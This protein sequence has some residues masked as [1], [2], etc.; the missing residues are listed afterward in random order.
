M[1]I[2]LNEKVI[3]R[4]L[5]VVQMYLC[6]RWS[7]LVSGGSVSQDCHWCLHKNINKCTTPL[8]CTFSPW[9]QTLSPILLLLHWPRR[10]LR[11]PIR[12]MSF[13]IESPTQF[14]VVCPSLWQTVPWNQK[15]CEDEGK[16][17]RRGWRQECK[18][19]AW[20]QWDRWKNEGK[21]EERDREMVVIFM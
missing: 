12:L 8:C 16:K 11:N 17:E 3:K 10:L 14:P 6:I 2:W 5:Q 15:W 1:V 21:R 18:K 7:C 9:S 4:F 13:L 19:E 20:S